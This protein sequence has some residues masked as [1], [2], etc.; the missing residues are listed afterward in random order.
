MTAAD[1]PTTGAVPTCYRHPDR[2]TYLR[3]TRCERPI[4]PDCMREAPVGQ[5][6]PECVR[7][8]QH[9]T[10]TPRT[11]F[12]GVSVSGTTWVTWAFLGIN[13]LVYLA[14][15]GVVGLA[16]QLAVYGV[17]I[18]QGEW[19]RALTG[20]FLHTAWWHIL[21]NMYALFIVGPHL[22]RMLGHWRFAV[23]YLVS[24]LSGSAL[25]LAVTGLGTLSLGASGAIYGLFGAVFMVF[26]RLRL[27]T[28]WIITTIAIN[29]VI[30]FIFVNAIDWKGHVGGLIAG[31][32]V[33]A[34]Y[35]YAP[36]EHRLLVQLAVPVGLLLVGAGAVLMRL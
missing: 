32:L 3:C 1:E 22:E 4:C 33:A 9:T 31:V 27:D 24:A 30:T 13:V 20:T 14:T 28:R 19:Y 10:R 25:S 2:E 5:Q 17:G 12:G 7:E 8:G 6:C 36:K 18:A 16:E 26:R 11:V 34:G 35:A 23:L 15:L 29:L 21:V